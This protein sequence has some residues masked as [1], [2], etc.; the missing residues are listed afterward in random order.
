MGG[1]IEIKE[2]DSFLMKIHTQA[3]C[4]WDT[5]K[6]CGWSLMKYRMQTSPTLREKWF[7]MEIHALPAVCDLGISKSLN[8]FL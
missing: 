8:G 7:L 1:L 2:E 5:S 6:S 3:T 4:A